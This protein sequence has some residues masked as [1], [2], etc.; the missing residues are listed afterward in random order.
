[1]LDW[2]LTVSLALGVFS[3]LCC[4]FVYG[5]NGSVILM[6]FFFI[7]V[8]FIPSVVHLNNFIEKNKQTMYQK[9]YGQ[10]KLSVLRYCSLVF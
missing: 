5:L 9:Q 2:L 6:V 4:S 8:F 7:A 3:E 1:M 10:Q